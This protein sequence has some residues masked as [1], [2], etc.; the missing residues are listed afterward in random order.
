VPVEAAGQTSCPITASPDGFTVPSQTATAQ[1]RMARQQI[2]IFEYAASASLTIPIVT[3]ANYRLIGPPQSGFV[4]AQKGGGVILW[5]TGGGLTT[6]VIADSQSP[7]SSGA[8]MQVTP[9]IQIAGKAAQVIYAGLSPG[10]P[11]L[12]QINV[13]VP[14]DAPSGKTTMTVAS[15][16]GDVNYDLWVQ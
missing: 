7:P 16:T 11:G 13:L 10:F 12:Y 14:L 15:G 5:T 8:P 3:D 2:A 9:A 4:Q 6:P 1:V